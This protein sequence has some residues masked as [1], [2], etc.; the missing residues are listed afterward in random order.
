MLQLL[1]L[2][3]ENKLNKGLLVLLDENIAAA[4]AAGQ[5]H[6][7][8]WSWDF[9]PTMSFV[10]RIFLESEPLVAIVDSSFWFWPFWFWTS[11]V[12]CFEKQDKMV[13]YMGKIR[14]AVVKYIT[15][16]TVTST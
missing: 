1:E 16:E 6:K 8:Y 13:E 14:E 15:V 7:L 4:S 9:T 3:G 10:D 5:V 12:V 2:A 11:F